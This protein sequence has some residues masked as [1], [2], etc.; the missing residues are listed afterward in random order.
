MR[1]HHVASAVLFMSFKDDYL[2]S[3]KSTDIY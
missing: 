2:L 1:S 3:L